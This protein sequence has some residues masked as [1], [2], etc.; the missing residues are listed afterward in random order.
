VGSEK[1]MFD[2]RQDRYITKGIQEQVNPL[3]YLYLWHLIDTMKVSRKDYLQ[4]FELKRVPG[5]AHTQVVIHRQECPRYKKKHVFQ[6]AEPQSI[7]RIFVIDDG[8]HS[9]M[10]LASEY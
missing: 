10:L 4:V 7:E 6:T 3:L 2:E 8:T 5:Q 1:I 9:T